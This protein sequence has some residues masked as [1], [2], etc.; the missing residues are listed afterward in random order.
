MKKW[1]DLSL[2]NEKKDTQDRFEY[3]N[4]A[5]GLKEENTLNNFKLHPYLH[6]YELRVK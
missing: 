2:D 6:I 5:M 4:K 3:T 1:I